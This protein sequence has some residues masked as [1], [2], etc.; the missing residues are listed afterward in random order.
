MDEFKVGEPVYLKSGG[1][2]MSIQSI[3]GENALCVWLDGKRPFREL[4]PLAVLTKEDPDSAFAIIPG[5][6]VP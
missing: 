3:D 1:P 4:Y 5:R 6:R 2:A